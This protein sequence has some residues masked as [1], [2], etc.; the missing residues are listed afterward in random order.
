[1]RDNKH[2]VL[3]H[4]AWSRGEQL[5]PA[6]AAF[7]E[8]GYT[9]HTP[10]LRH[11][12]LPSR[13]GAMRGRLT[14]PFRLH[15]RLG[16][17]REFA[18]FPTASHWSLDGPAGGAVGR[19]AYT[20]SWLT[21]GMP[22]HGYAPSVSTA[23]SRRV[24]DLEQEIRELKRANEILKRAAS[25]SGAELDRQHK[26]IVVFIDA[27]RDEFGVKPQ[28]DP[29]KPSMTSNRPPWAGCTG[30]TPTAYTATTKTARR[31]GSHVLRCETNQTQTFRNPTARAD[32]R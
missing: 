17:V 15:R 4:G 29:G 7:E 11:H 10:T 13:E 14:E 24:R 19:R 16:G 28:P 25:F 5:A 26:N 3:I 30:T 27:N 12:E 22:R 1:M 23:E 21:G 18:G 8:R 6:R 9:A 31:V 32:P 20:P 2:V